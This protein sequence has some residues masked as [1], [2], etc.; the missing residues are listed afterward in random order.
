MKVKLV[1][2]SNSS[3]LV[4]KLVGD[5]TKIA[6]NKSSYNF[7]ITPQKNLLPFLNIIQKYWSK[8]NYLF[9]GIKWFISS[10]VIN[11][12]YKIPLFYTYLKTNFF[13]HI[14][15]S[16]NDVFYPSTKGNLIDNSLLFDRQ[17]SSR[18]G[19]DLLVCMMD[20]K[21]QLAYLKN[22]LNPSKRM[23]I[24]KLDN[25]QKILTLGLTSILEIKKIMIIYTGTNHE[26]INRINNPNRHLDNVISY[27]NYH[28]DT[29]VFY[30]SND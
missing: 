17:I 6:M 13:D 2:F 15:S 14:N 25:G 3:D 23:D 29:T 10:E 12:Q 21:G 1:K 18:K 30:I 28:D 22:D 11:D 20:E 8:N 26:V 9:P 7:C 16:Q 5:I 19:L 24:I 4:K 27:F